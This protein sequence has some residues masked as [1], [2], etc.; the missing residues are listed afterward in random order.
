MEAVTILALG[1]ICMAC[2]L[3]G[4]KVGQATAKG[5]KIET[6]TINPMEAW[7]NRQDKKETQAEQDKIDTILQNIE[8]YDG[9]GRGQ[10]DVPGR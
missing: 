5:E 3:T 9:T 7:R 2:F 10:K 1:F 6:P 8:S 4:A